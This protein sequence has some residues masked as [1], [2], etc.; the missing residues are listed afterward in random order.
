MPFVIELDEA[1]EAKPP[2]AATPA[3]VVPVAEIEAQT[4]LTGAGAAPVSTEPVKTSAP[5]PQEPVDFKVL[6]DSLKA[7]LASFDSVGVAVPDN[8]LDVRLRHGLVELA[9]AL[10]Y[11]TYDSQTCATFKRIIYKDKDKGD[12]DFLTGISLR[13]NGQHAIVQWGDHAIEIDDDTSLLDRNPLYFQPGSEDNNYSLVALP[14]TLKFPISIAFDREKLGKNH[15]NKLMAAETVGDLK[16]LLKIEGDAQSL[17][18]IEGDFTFTVKSKFEFDRKDGKGKSVLLLVADCE[19]PKLWAPGEAEFWL[20]TTYP[21]SASREGQKLTVIDTTGTVTEISIGRS[22]EK[23]N[24][25]EPGTYKVVGYT[26]YETQWGERSSID[27]LIGGKPKS[28]GTQC[29]GYLIENRLKDKPEVSPEKPA[30]LVITEIQTGSRKD[31]ATGTMLEF[32]SVICKFILDSDK[33]NPLMAAMMAKQQPAAIP[34]SDE[35]PF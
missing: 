11:S 21:L 7:Q 20:S 4:E 2:V 23:L 1:V 3:P 24:T 9:G 34:D 13:S 17:S 29:K 25:L 32:K 35:E 19:Y 15:A 33:S 28:F 8:A 27:I 26:F 14:K 10:G 18:K 31:R 5:A 30:D 6:L 16:P 22:V 12:R